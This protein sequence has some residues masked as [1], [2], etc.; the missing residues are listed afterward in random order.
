MQPGDAVAGGV[1]KAINLAFSFV[2]R[3][4]RERCSALIQIH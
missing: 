1:D 3:F 4:S 2:S